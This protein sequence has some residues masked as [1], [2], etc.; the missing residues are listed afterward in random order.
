[1]IQVLV[2]E[3]N[4]LHTLAHTHGPQAKTAAQMERIKVLNFQLTVIEDA[5]SETLGEGSRYLEGLVMTCLLLLVLT[6]ESTGI[7]L[8]VSFSRNLSRTLNQLIEVARGV[9][10]GDFTTRA[11]VDSKD[12]LGQLAIA[13]NS[14]TAQLEENVGSRIQAEEAS[15][16]KS[17]FFGEHV[18]RDP[19]TSRSHFRF[20]RNFKRRVANGRRT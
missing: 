4:R 2:V 5:F 9:G 16:T 1:M 11:S 17:A 12:E 14:M 20:H 7:L 15:Q 19:N 13:L 10:R 18:T 6:V 3:A 8:T